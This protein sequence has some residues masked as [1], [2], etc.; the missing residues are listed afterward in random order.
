MSR[1]TSAQ[2][3]IAWREAARI[4]RAWSR[5]L[6]ASGFPLPFDEAVLIHMSD[7]IV[8]SLLQR[9]RII[10]RRKMRTAR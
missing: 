2:K 9:S 6:L 3:A 7:Q 1:A 8:P 4:V 10:A 5:G